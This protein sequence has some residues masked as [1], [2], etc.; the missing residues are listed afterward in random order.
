M[1]TVFVRNLCVHDR[2]GFF[3]D[4]ACICVLSCMGDLFF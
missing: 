3:V 4:L 1:Y 2:E